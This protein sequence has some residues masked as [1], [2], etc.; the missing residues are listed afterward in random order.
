MSSKFTATFVLLF[1]LTL[2]IGL[3]AFPQADSP[4]PTEAAE[5]TF[6]KIKAF[7]SNVNLTATLSEIQ[8]SPIG[9]FISQS[10]APKNKTST[11]VDEAKDSKPAED[12][13]SKIWSSFTST[14]QNL[15]KQTGI[16]LSS[17][18][19]K[20]KTGDTAWTPWNVRRQTQE[21]VNSLKAKKT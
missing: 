7:I 6:S 8:N 10:I 12:Q 15:P 4:N 11:P 1:V 17:L 3:E 18:M 21:A 20:N 14:L 2:T 16:D 13:I 5:N 19:P 9:T